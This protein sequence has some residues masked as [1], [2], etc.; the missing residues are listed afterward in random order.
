MYWDKI[1]FEDNNNFKDFKVKFSDRDSLNGVFFKK[2]KD[3]YITSMSAFISLEHNV[4]EL[5]DYKQIKKISGISN[6]I[7]ENGFEHLYEENKLELIFEDQKNN[8]QPEKSKRKLSLRVVEFFDEK[9]KKKRIVSVYS[10]YEELKEYGLIFENKG[11]SVYKYTINLITERDNLFLEKRLF[12][13]KKK[14]IEE[15]KKDIDRKNTFFIRNN[16]VLKVIKLEITDYL[17]ERIDNRTNFDMMAILRNKSEFPLYFLN[18]L[19]H[20]Y[21]DKPR[22]R[23]PHIFTVGSN[24]TDLHLIAVNLTNIVIKGGL[25]LYLTPELYAKNKSIFKYLDE[26]SVTDVT[27]QELTTLRRQLNDNDFT[28]SKIYG[29]R[30]KFAKT[31]YSSLSID[32]FVIPDFNVS[33]KVK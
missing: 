25:D 14:I 19:F 23:L 8:L 33:V 3:Y 12:F 31:Y 5:K 27:P 17:A 26:K 9:T 22:R 10:P 29:F 13:D 20:G 18:L 24:V 21:G 2:N 7:L 32:D 1:I 6:A 11:G 28:V 15:I 30:S 16:G 4:K